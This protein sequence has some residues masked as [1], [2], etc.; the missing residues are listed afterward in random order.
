MS[1]DLCQVFV[2]SEF[3]QLALE[4]SVPAEVMQ[5]LSEFEVATFARCCTS[6]A[7]AEDMIA[8][9]CADSGLVEHP[10]K[11][12]AKASLR[13][14]L[15]RCRVAEALPSLEQHT[16][17]PSPAN[18]PT[19]P[20]PT[21]TPPTPASSGW[22]ESWPAKLSPEKTAALRRRFEEDYPTELLDSE[23]FPSSRLLALTSKMIADKEIRWLPWKFRLSSKSQDDNLLLR[24]KKQPRLSELSDLLLDD[25]P[26]REIHDGPASY[27]FI[28]QMLS[29][30][31][32]SIAL[33]QGAHLGALKMYNKKFLQLCFTKYE[34]A[35]NLRGPTSLEAQAADKRA[36]EILSDLVN[37]HSWKLDDALHEVSE[38]RSD[39]ASLLAP[40]PHV[41]KRLLEGQDQWRYRPNGRGRGAQSTGRGG[42]G[43]DGKGNPAERLE[44]GGKG[45]TSQKGG[46]KHGQAPQGKW[47]STIFMDGKKHTLCMRYQSGQCRDPTSCRYV[48]KCAVPKQDGTACGGNHPASQHV[49]TS[50]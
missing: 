41:S 16:M 21:A 31:S 23:S 22:Q 42:K 47:L 24:P 38:V 29:L 49:S 4:A 11:L 25:A 48:H 30:A 7:E 36:W 35:S 46:D 9:L 20:L 33:C 1:P 13:L 32:T 50:H 18:L 44:R 12:L 10:S 3:S 14:L 34:P 40:R 15:S 2:M 17:L 27:A 8:Q 26:T 5:L 39:L 19:P 6:H 28:S 43:R 45:K 37:Q